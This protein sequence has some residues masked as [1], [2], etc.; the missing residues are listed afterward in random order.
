LDALV[1]QASSHPEKQLRGPSL[2][3]CL[4]E[5]TLLKAA[6]LLEISVSRTESA[7]SSLSQTT[8]QTLFIMGRIVPIQHSHPRN[9]HGTVVS[10][11]IVFIGF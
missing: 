4:A 9:A 6:A 8:A 1:R 10:H 7:K 3:R 2:A 5:M 11:Y